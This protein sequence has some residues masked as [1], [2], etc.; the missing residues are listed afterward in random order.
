MVIIMNG[1]ISVKKAAALWDITERQVQR[2]C[3][4]GRIPGVL[5]FGNSWAIPNGTAKPTRTAKSK[6]GRKKKSDSK[7]ESEAYVKGGIW[8]EK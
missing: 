1:Y 6:P 5:R 3:E 2:I 4:S 7:L 8:D